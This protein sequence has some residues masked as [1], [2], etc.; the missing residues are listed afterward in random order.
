MLLREQE[1]KE[2]VRRIVK[3]AVT[4]E[5]GRTLLAQRTQDIL[6]ALTISDGPRV[7]LVRRSLN[8]TLL[9]PSICMRLS[10]VGC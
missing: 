10:N 7:E 8:Q 3:Y 9:H 5:G 6:H 4:D 1:L 2:L